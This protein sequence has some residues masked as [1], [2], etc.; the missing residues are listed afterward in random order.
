ML[1]GGLFLEWIDEVRLTEAG[2]RGG[3][4]GTWEALGCAA[5]SRYTAHGGVPAVGR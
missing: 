4:G 5:A 1:N 2:V 3:E